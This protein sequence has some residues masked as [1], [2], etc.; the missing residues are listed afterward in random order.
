MNPLQLVNAISDWLLAGVGGI[1]TLAGAIVGNW[2]RST[3]N[4]RRLEGDDADPNNEGALQMISDTQEELQEFRRETREAHEEV[5]DRID[6]L[7]STGGDS[8]GD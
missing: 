4:E 7:D 2:R 3:R 8:A 5:M 1:A 6:E